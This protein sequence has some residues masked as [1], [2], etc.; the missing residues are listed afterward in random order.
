VCSPQT[1]RWPRSSASS[2][3]SRS[4]LYAVGARVHCALTR[5]MAGGQ[6]VRRELP[7]HAAA[8]HAG[9]YD[10]ARREAHAARLPQ[11]V[12]PGGGGVVW[13]GG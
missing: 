10:L 8:G 5:R 11:G 6:V 13:R 3:S 12:F 1:H 4:T 2:R 9:R 7:H